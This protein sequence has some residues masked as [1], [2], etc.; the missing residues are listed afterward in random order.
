MEKDAFIKLVSDVYDHLYDHVFLRNCALLDL[1]VTD[2]RMTSKERAWQ[3]HHMLLE[4]IEELDPGAKA[5][6]FSQE[7][8]RYQLLVLHYV[9]GLDP[10]SVADQLAI[11]RR[12]FYREREVALRGVG[13]LLW[14]NYV[15]H[16]HHAQPVSES[17]DEEPSIKRLE[18]L[19]L[20]AVR[21]ARADRVMPLL[22]V[23][24]GAIE[25][26]R[27][28]ADTIDIELTVNL[29]HQ[30]IPIGIDRSILRQILV[31]LL[32]HLA[33]GQSGKIQVSLS[34]ADDAI[35]ASIRGTNEAGRDRVALEQ[36]AETEL[37][38]LQELATMQGAELCILVQDSDVVEYHL[39]I[40]LLETHTILVVDDNEDVLQLFERYLGEQRYPVV[41]AHTG[42]EAIRLAKEVK[43]YAIT[44]DLMMP[45]QDGWDIL[46]TLTNQPET[47]HI[48]VIVCTVLGAKELA[49][50]LGATAFLEKPVTQDMLLTA[51]RRLDE[52]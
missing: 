20:E 51:L 6:V 18:L 29:G 1:L 34:L 19:R 33:A 35:S 14:D 49:L 11:S 5:P 3:L 16:Q 12:H 2:S 8:R 48:P 36:G 10:Q 21:S 25:L 50:S 38:L 7:S 9:D 27:R 43:P 30:S 15:V 31:G 13:E 28:A 41:T 32:G 46:Q 4:S 39:S 24:N 45:E 23:V 26:V 22:E 40:P 37:S 17:E 44:L 52:V 42:A 47:Q